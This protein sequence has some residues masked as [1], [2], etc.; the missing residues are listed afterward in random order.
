[1]PKDETEAD[2][3]WALEKQQAEPAKHKEYFK[4]SY[5]GDLSGASNFIN[6]MKN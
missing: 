2:V 6:K 4:G 1:M 3:D 5:I